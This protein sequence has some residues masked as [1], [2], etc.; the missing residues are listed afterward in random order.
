LL[1]TKEEK[2][3][4]NILNAGISTERFS[5]TPT[6]ILS[7]YSRKYSSPTTPIVTGY[8]STEPSPRLRTTLNSFSSH[9][10]KTSTG[11]FKNLPEIS[12]FTKNFHSIKKARTKTSSELKGTETSPSFMTGKVWDIKN[13][14]KIKLESKETKKI[15]KI[16]HRIPNLSKKP[17]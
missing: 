5:N 17:P 4:A 16:N 12:N 1:D 7:I 11:E 2:K 9:S 15:I 14:H 8:L 6:Q 13:F 10:K 3:S